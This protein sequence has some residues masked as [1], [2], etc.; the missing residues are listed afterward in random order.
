MQFRRPEPGVVISAAV[1]AI[2]LLASLVAFSSTPKFEDAQESIPVEMITENEMNQIM[3]GERNAKPDNQKP[4]ADVKSE[5]AE[6]TPAPPVKEAKVDIPTPPPPLKRLPDPAET[7]T[8]EPPKLAALPPQRPAPEVKPEPAPPEP[9]VRPPQAKVEPPKPVVKE[10]PEPVKQAE[11]KPE[12]EDTRPVPLPPRRP[13]L[14]RKVEEK[15][16]PDELARLEE[17]TRDVKPEPRPRSG[18][19]SAEPRKYDPTTI[20]RILSKEPAQARASTGATPSQQAAL[21]SPTANA[22]KMSPNMSAQLNGLLIEQY[23]RCWTYIGNAQGREYQPQVT[24]SY[25]QSGGLIGRPVLHNPPSDPAMK[26]LAESAMRAVQRCNPLQI[27][28]QFIPYYNEWKELLLRF[29]PLEM[30]G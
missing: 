1:H 21:G 10:A 24:V 20:S 25:S 19:E 9:P 27:P 26:S 28:A 3:K 5:Q 6:Q 2:V 30:M 16:K 13:N 7:E 18:E 17:T 23:K 15:P 14:P 22:A 12:P 8:P 29:D 4:R 11:A